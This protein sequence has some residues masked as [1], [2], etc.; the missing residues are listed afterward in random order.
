M[1]NTRNNRYGHKRQRKRES[2]D[3][4]VRNLS[5]VNLTHGQLRVLNKGLQF[6]PTTFLRCEDL[7][8][9]IE[10]ERL[11]R[12]I[13]LNFK[14]ERNDDD[15]KDSTVFHVLSN[16]M[17]PLIRSH[18]EMEQFLGD[19]RRGIPLAIDKC[20]EREKHHGFNLNKEEKHALKALKT[21]TSIVIK[22]AD[23]GGSL[24]VMD[25]EHYLNG[26][27]RQ[28]QDVRYYKAL[29][30]SI[31]GETRDQ[32]TEL[33]QDLR[34]GGH[35]DAK[36]YSFLLPPPD[37]KLR[38]F[39]GLPKVHK[40][41]E[42]WPLP[43]KEPP[44]RP[45]CP[46]V[47]TA[48]THLSQW[49]DFHIQPLAQRMLKDDLVKDSYDFVERL[50]NL[51]IPE[52][53]PIILLAIDVESLYTNIPHQD[54]IEAIRESYERGAGR[55]PLTNLL[56]RALNLILSKNDMIFDG[57]NYLQVKGVAM[58]TNAAPA[59]ANIFMERV[60]I[61][62]RNFNPIGYFRFIDDLFIVWDM[63]RNLQELKGCNQQLRS[64]SSIHIRRVT[65]KQHIFRSR[66][67]GH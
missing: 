41:E 34:I 5:R 1:V 3:N 29:G 27:R 4:Q 25:R 14:F 47:G 31:Q 46:N 2:N 38:E 65:R 7:C 40:K 16:Y 23:K 36:L 24:V 56:C 32:V 66:G 26:G 12:Q 59:I 45:V 64:E 18:P 30:Q 48:L 21:M 55:K 37:P 50:K 39:Y 44:L 20:I 8:M 51:V 17:P 57:K 28:L 35:I 43:G 13:R 9:K 60:D 33:V 54:G 15:V 67:D 42:S 6:V 22:P 53:T 10:Q 11:D 52:D 19:F 58:G 62:V 63:R 49:V 61:C